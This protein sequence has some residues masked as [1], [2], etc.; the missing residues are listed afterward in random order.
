MQQ[1]KRRKFVEPRQWIAGWKRAAQRVADLRAG[2]LGQFKITLDRVFAPIHFGGAAVKE[3]RA[4]PRIAHSENLFRAADPG[5]ERAPEQSLKIER[6]VGP[7]L[8]GFFEPRHHAD[9]RAQ[10]GEIAARKNV[11]VVHVG[12]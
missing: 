10:S 3:T 8:S 7:N 5:D 1:N 6:D 12:I 9:W 4:F 2:E 11:D